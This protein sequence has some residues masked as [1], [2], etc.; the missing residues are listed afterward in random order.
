MK[1]KYCG[2]TRPKDIETAVSLGVDYI[3][4]VLYP[5]SPR[6]ISS[7]K[8]RELLKE[9]EKMLK[10]SATKTVVVC[11]NYPEKNLAD[12]VKKLKIDVIQLHGEET[13]E[14][15]QQL[16]AYLKQ[17][18]EKKIEIFKALRLKNNIKKEEITALIKNY[19]ENVDAFVVEARHKDYGGTGKSLEKEVVSQVFSVGD[20]WQKKIFLSGGVSAE[21]LPAIKENFSSHPSFFGL[22]TSSALETKKG[23]KSIDKMRDFYKIFA[24][25]Q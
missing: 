17:A 16:C 3:G 2:L 23:L 19:D 7:E 1:L 9:S 11:V 21:K 14:N 20:Q 22:D 5:P 6:Y 13:K 24:E 10:N 8:L 15:I 12:L 18:G 25:N 4:F